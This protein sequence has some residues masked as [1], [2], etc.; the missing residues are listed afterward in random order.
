[1]ARD[2]LVNAASSLPPV[3][4]AFT[5]YT[6]ATTY[7]CSG[8]I[9]PVVLLLPYS[10][11]N[12]STSAPTPMPQPKHATAL[13]F[14]QPTLPSWKVSEHGCHRARCIVVT[15]PT[16]ILLPNECWLLPRPHTSTS[17]LGSSGL[18][19]ASLSPAFS[20]KPTS[21]VS[22]LFPVTYP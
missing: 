8:Q 10:L 5:S 14:L 2:L 4:A 22:Q 1:M 16:A 13:A 11:H 6:P 7:F 21:K 19:C 3:L 20:N 9:E 17:N 15:R 18:T 12:V